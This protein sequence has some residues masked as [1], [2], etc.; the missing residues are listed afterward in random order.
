MPEEGEVGRWILFYLMTGGILLLLAGLFYPAAAVLREL[1][2]RTGQGPSILIPLSFLLL[3]FLAAF[4]KAW[5]LGRRRRWVAAYGWLMGGCALAVV[6]L[7]AYLKA[8]TGG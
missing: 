4:V 2:V 6:L 8:M 5:H 7:Y 1:G 3:S